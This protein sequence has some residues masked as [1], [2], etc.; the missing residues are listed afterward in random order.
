MTIFDK[1]WKI[2]KEDM[3]CCGEP[4]TYKESGMYDPPLG[5]LEPV[6]GPPDLDSHSPIWIFQCER[7][8]KVIEDGMQDGAYP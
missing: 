2:V 6:S 7:C 4:M 3:E 5:S 8:G 1:A